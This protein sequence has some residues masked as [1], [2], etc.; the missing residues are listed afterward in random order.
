MR[1]QMKRLPG[2]PFFF[3]AASAELGAVS[4]NNARGRQ[5]VPAVFKLD[6]RERTT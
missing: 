1:F 5:L 6:N 4:E 3:L 2:K